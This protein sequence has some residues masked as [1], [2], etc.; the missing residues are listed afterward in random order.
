[1]VSMDYKAVLSPVISP[2]LFHKQSDIT[3][4]FART[5][6]KTKLPNGIKIYGNEDVIEQIT[7]LVN[8]YL[9]I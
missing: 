7:H 8:E 9:F 6:L 4:L 1:M 2:L 3:I 5:S